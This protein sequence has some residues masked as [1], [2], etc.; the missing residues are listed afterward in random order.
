MTRPFRN[1]FLSN[2]IERWNIEYI[3]IHRHKDGLLNYIKK[4]KK[5]RFT[6]S[7]NI[8]NQLKDFYLVYKNKKKLSKLMK[9]N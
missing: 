1:T 3:A 2:M 7:Q 5:E 8:C 9:L 6:N 4:K